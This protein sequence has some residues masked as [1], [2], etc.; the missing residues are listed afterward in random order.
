MESPYKLIYENII[1]DENISEAQ[2]V[3]ERKYKEYIDNHKKNVIET[4]EE[5]KK[6]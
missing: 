3:Q 6:K 2:K 5:L 1:K 4:W